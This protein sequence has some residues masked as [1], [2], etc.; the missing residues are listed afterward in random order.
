MHYNVVFDVTQTG[1]RYW[2]S[3]LLALIFAAIPIA[4]ISYK[5]ITRWR[6]SGRNI[7]FLIF[8]SAFGAVVGAFDFYHHHSNYLRLQSAIR[9][10][11]CVITEGI[12]TQFQ[13]L[14]D[15]KNRVGESFAVNGVE[16]RYRDRSAQ[17][18]FNQVGLIKN[19]MQVR[20]FHFDEDDSIDKDIAR[21]EIA[22]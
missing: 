8:V 17:N 6:V 16:F 1:Y 3:L 12:V 2:S 10:S 19:G 5:G 15:D 4:I 22:Q 18:G 13:I 14:P 21:L 7:K 20:V 9:E 11:K